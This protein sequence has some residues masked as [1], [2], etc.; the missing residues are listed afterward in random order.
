M[1][2]SGIVTISVILVSVIIIG[3]CALNKKSKDSSKVQEK[4]VNKTLSAKGENT[5]N[6]KEEDR[7]R[8]TTQATREAMR[9]GTQQ[10]NEPVAKK[11][12]GKVIVID[13]GHA[14]RSNLVTEQQA[15]GSSIYKIKDGGG[16]E[17]VVTHTP[18]YLVNMLV[19]MKLKQDLEQ[20]GYTVVMT[21]TD[22]SVSLGNIDRANIGNASNAA[23]VI[24]IHADSSDSSSIKGASMLVPAP[25]NENT[26]AIYSESKRCGQIVLNAL[27]SQVGMENKGVVERDDM[28]GFNWSKV[29]VILVEMGFLSN[30]DEDSLLK[31]SDYQTKLAMALANGIQVAIK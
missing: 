7:Y 16:A 29:P 27:T 19:S 3:A 12:S 22:N 9:K 23:L 14:N 2:K 17:G 4:N 18:E 8:N 13:P 28:T 21:K 25:I 11:A 10:K 30:Q 15:P 1:K 6:E 5:Q 26:K 31:T 20:M 24:R